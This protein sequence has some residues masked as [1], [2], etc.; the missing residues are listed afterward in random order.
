[1]I[2]LVVFGPRKLVELGRSLDEA[3]PSSKGDETVQNTL[4]QE[5]NADEQRTKDAA[6][7]TTAHVE[8]THIPDA[9]P[10]VSKSA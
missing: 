4:E 8:P 5:I 2:A 1:V 6:A 10:P 3:L 7:E 9:A